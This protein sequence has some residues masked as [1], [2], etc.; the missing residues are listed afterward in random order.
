MRDLAGRIRRY[1]GL[2]TLPGLLC[3]P[4]DGRGSAR[5]RT[6]RRADRGFGFG[7]GPDQAAVQLSVG[8]PLVPEPMKPKVVP[9]PAASEP[10]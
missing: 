6:V 1:I 9:A 7:S 4:Y 3:P 5:R 10:L 8:L 2:K